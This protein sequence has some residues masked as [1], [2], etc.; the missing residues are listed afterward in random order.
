M[1]ATILIA[2]DDVVQRR[3]VENMVQKGGYET[4][5]VDG[6]VAAGL[7]VVGLL[8]DHRV[9]A[10]HDH[11]AGANFLSGFHRTRELEKGVRRNWLHP[12]KSL[13]F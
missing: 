1:A 5:V 2:E 7:V 10:D 11:I 9:A 12:P 6:G 8:P 3:L 4:A 13:L